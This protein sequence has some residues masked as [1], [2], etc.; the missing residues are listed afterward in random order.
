MTDGQW[1]TRPELE[2]EVLH[3][4]G[5]SAIG[6]ELIDWILERRLPQDFIVTILRN[7]LSDALRQ[8]KNWHGVHSLV[9]IEEFLY[10]WAPSG[11]WGSYE[12]VNLWKKKTEN[13]WDSNMSRVADDTP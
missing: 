3:C 13:N 4:G 7:N 10:N 11:C 9:Q 6:E 2:R 12:R 1:I 5:D 8:A